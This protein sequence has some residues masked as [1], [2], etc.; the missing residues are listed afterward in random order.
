MKPLFF[1]M[2]PL[3]WV[4]CQPIHFASD[5]E[6]GLRAAS[7]SEDLPWEKKE[8]IE[9]T[10]VSN[11]LDLVFIF[12]VQPGM[13]KFYENPLLKEEFLNGLDNYDVKMAYTN[14]AVDKKLLEKKFKNDRECGFSNL[15]RGTGLTVASVKFPL[16]WPFAIQSADP[17]LSLD[18]SEKFSP[19]VN[20][21]F[22]P[23]ELEGEKLSSQLLQGDENYRTV[24]QH[25]FKKNTAGWI[26]AYDAPQSQGEDSHPLS[27][28]FL[29]LAR[30]PSFFRK[31]S[32]VVFVIFASTDTPET[33]SAQTIRQNFANIYEIENRLHIIPVVNDEKDSLCDLRLRELGVKSPQPG[34]HLSQIASDMGMQSLNLCS[35]N[36]SQEL[37]LAIQSL[38]VSGES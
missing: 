17:C 3:F 24:F 5:K 36:L 9:D 27:A 16:L 32:Q 19:K 26:N 25:T 1:F 4:A 7:I 14:T 34:V 29:S 10:F 38:L 30:N 37:L 6:S 20:G 23:F 31:D 8:P 12:D 35:L 2:F 11:K 28:M 13:D 21:E 33:V 22:L 18:F 15:L